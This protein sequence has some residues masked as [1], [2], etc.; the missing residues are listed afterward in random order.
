[1]WP[2]MRRIVAWLEQASADSAGVAAQH[3]VAA[4]AYT[5]ALATMPTL[6]ELAANHVIHGVLVGDEFLWHQHDSDRPQRGRLRADVGSGRHD[7]GSTY[8]VGIGCGAGVGAANHR[9]AAN[10]V[11]SAGAAQAQQPVRRPASRFVLT[12][13][14]M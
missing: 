8:Q 13:N 4:T 9:G 10:I 5:A 3:E 11:K 1:M 6:V 7:H 2:R 14:S 12:A